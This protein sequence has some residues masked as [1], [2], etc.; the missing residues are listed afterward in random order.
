MSSTP[1]VSCKR[2]TFSF[3][4]PG[5]LILPHF[6]FSCSSSLSGLC[7]ED[8]T[9]AYLAVFLGVLEPIRPRSPLIPQER[10]FDPAAPPAGG[11]A[12][13]T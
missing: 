5:Q 4:P 9:G 13:R 2:F 7:R 3:I 8:E 12:V 10:S 1:S 11:A 6:R